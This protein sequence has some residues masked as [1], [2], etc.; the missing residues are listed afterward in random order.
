[1]GKLPQAYKETSWEIKYFP[2]KTNWAFKI[3][4]DSDT[5]ICN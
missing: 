5:E 3:N 2:I 1:M 4:W